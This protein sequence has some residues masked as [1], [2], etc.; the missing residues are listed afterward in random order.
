MVDLNCNTGTEND[1][2]PLRN[3]KQKLLITVH[4]TGGY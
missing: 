3:P 2:F 1:V 4:F